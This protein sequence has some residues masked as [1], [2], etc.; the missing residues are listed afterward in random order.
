[1]TVPN[2]RADFQARGTTPDVDPASTPQTQA[3]PHTT[4]CEAGP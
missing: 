1:M 3:S 4:L 2:N